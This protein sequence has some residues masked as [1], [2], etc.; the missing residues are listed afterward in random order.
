[1]DFASEP[2][3]GKDCASKYRDATWHSRV[4]FILATPFFRVLRGKPHSMEVFVI[5]NFHAEAS[6][7]L[8]AIEIEASVFVLENLGIRKYQELSNYLKRL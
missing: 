5:R 3:M 2:A 8:K 1:M 7:I 6:I 4:D